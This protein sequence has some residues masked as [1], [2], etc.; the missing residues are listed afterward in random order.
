MAIVRLGALNAETFRVAVDEVY[1]EAVVDGFM[2][3]EYSTRQFLNGIGIRDAAAVAFWERQISRY[4][5]PAPVAVSIVVE[6]AK[7]PRPA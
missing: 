3:P 7:P 4:Y 6:F 1:R 2:N 5:E